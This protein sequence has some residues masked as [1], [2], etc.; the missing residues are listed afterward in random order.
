MLIG[1]FT[2]AWWTT[3][4]GIVVQRIGLLEHD[5]CFEPP[6]G[7]GY[8]DSAKHG[9]FRQGLLDAA[10]WWQTYRPTLVKRLEQRRLTAPGQAQARSFLRRMDQLLDTEHAEITAGNGTWIR[11]GQILYYGT[12]AVLILLAVAV[13]LTRTAAD[14]AAL[15]D[16]LAAAGCGALL[17][18]ALAFVARAPE[19]IKSAEPALNAGYSRWLYWLGAA[20][21]VASGVLM[22]MSMSDAGET[23]A[24]APARPRGKGVTAPGQ[25]ASAGDGPTCGS[26]G[27][28]AIFREDVKTYICQRCG[29]IV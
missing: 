10:A 3:E 15:V 16:K 21:G 23:P 20:A 11:M 25:P 4:S 6:A 1:V 7:R 13:T 5:V 26:C 29:T 8:C 9:V 17:L 22:S 24:R 19:Y 28:Q 12:F 14:R 2:K 27:A 18:V